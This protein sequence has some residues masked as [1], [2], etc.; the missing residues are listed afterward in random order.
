MLIFDGDCGL[1]TRC[2][3]WAQRR[4]PAGE[5]VVAWQHLDDLGAVGLTVDDVTAAAWWVDADGTRYRGHLAVGKALEACG[6]GWRPLGAALGRPGVSAVAALVY[7]LV[8]RNRYRLP[9]GTPACRM[10]PPDPQP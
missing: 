1:C 5:R 10:P 3:E 7:D 4:L 8:A 9:G 6:R 2:A